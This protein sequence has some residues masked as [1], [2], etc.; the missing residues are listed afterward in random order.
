MSLV[1]SIQGAKTVEVHTNAP[2]A[3]PSPLG[4]PVET[5]VVVI[6]TPQMPVA[7]DLHPA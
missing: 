1:V 7:A 2:E 4:T 5:M 3:A 6:A